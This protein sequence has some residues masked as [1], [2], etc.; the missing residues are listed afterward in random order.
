[1]TSCAFAQPLALIAQARTPS[2]TGMQR[3]DGNATTVQSTRQFLSAYDNDTCGAVAH[4][5]D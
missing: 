2:G 5:I 3:T 1:M 4:E